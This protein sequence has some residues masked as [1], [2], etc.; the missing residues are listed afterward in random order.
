MNALRAPTVPRRQGSSAGQ[1]DKIVLSTAMRT[2]LQKQ[3]DVLVRQAKALHEL[4]EKVESFPPGKMTHANLLEGAAMATLGKLELPVLSDPAAT[5]LC[6][7]RRLRMGTFMRDMELELVSMCDDSMGLAAAVHAQPFVRLLFKALDLEDEGTQNEMLIL[8][9]CALQKTTDGGTLAAFVE[10]EGLTALKHVLRRAF[11]NGEASTVISVLDGLQKLPVSRLSLRRSSIGRMVKKV[12]KFAEGSAAEN[13]AIVEGA[14]DLIQRWKTAIA[15]QKRAQDAEDAGLEDLVEEHMARARKS[16][17]PQR[18][19]K[20][21][22]EPPKAAKAAPPPPSAA[23]AAKAAAAPAPLDDIFEEAE[24]S[25]PARKRAREDPPAAPAKAPDAAQRAA[26]QAKAP[27]AEKE[28]AAKKRQRTS[29]QLSK[30]MT[31]PADAGLRAG[32]PQVQPSPAIAAKALSFGEGLSGG[33]GGGAAAAAAAAADGFEGGDAKVEPAFEEDMALREL[34][35]PSARPKGSCLRRSGRTARVAEVTKALDLAAHAK[36]ME[37]RQRG[38]EVDVGLASQSSVPT[39]DEVDALVRGAAEGGAGAG[40]GDKAPEEAKAPANIRWADRCKRQLRFIMFIPKVGS[41]SA[42]P[43][44]AGE[45]L[46]EGKHLKSI[47]SAPQRAAQRSMRRNMRGGKSGKGK[48]TVL[49][50]LQRATKGAALGSVEMRAAVP[51]QRPKNVEADLADDL[52]PPP[53]ES[54]AQAKE[55]QRIASGARYVAVL[56]VEA[57]PRDMMEGP[58]ETSWTHVQPTAIP[59]DEVKADAA[60]PPPQPVP[61]PQPPPPAQPPPPQGG[62]PMAYAP[63]G[64]SFAQPMAFGQPAPVAFGAGMGVAPAPAFGYAQQQPPPPPPPPGM[65]QQQQQQQQQRW[66]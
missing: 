59:F 43:G 32:K 63:A 35:D 20:P 18:A 60:P 7:N 37:R 64:Q 13:A 47:P 11:D 58:R 48:R 40:E 28:S 3:Q 4:F 25:A 5:K 1:N 8:L 36:L 62:P 46:E 15:Q 10:A 49:S 39:S 56:T 9:L 38:E 24:K 54:K 16:Q 26:E 2:V 57:L 22:P 44:S 31:S 6:A 52:L 17:R 50:P 14:Q 27:S 19:Q 65:P 66:S 12:C 21:R 23:T 55:A 61:P 45:L 42:G 51:W 29:L 33:G 34:P 53:A 30:L 41:R